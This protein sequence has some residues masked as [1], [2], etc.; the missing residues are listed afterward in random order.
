VEA[1][2]D[3]Q[4]AADE[5]SPQERRRLGRLGGVLMI[6][7]SLAVVPAA[8]FLDDPP[9]AIEHLVA[10]AGVLAGAG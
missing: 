2:D 4:E 1:L 5:L 6:I 10:L 7:G 3:P 8:A 9:D